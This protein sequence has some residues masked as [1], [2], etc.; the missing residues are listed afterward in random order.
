MEASFPVSW[1]NWL[2]LF[3]SSRFIY[4]DS[5]TATFSVDALAESSD[6]LPPSDEDLEEEDGEVESKNKENSQDLE[7][8][9]DDEEPGPA[10]PISTVISIKKP[11]SGTLQIMTTVQDDTF[12]I[13][14]VGFMSDSTLAENNTAE[15]DW[16][17]SGIYT[18]PVFSQLDEVR[19]DS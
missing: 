18:G 19:R 14:H 8:D 4:F 3:L 16:K 6:Y 2:A 9:G 11:N 5:I 10:Y 15:G 13:E 17:K 7:E 12:F 1:I